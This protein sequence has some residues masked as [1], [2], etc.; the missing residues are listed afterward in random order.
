MRNRVDEILNL[1]NQVAPPRP[2]FEMPGEDV[3]S[4]PVVEYQDRDAVSRVGDST[5]TNE[6]DQGLAF[7][8][9]SLA[10]E[11]PS[12]RDRDLIA[13]AGQRHRARALFYRLKANRY[14]DA[15]HGIDYALELRLVESLAREDHNSPVFFALISI[16]GWDEGLDRENHGCGY[17]FHYIMTKRRGVRTNVLLTFN[18]TED[19]GPPDTLYWEHHGCY[20]SANPDRWGT[21]RC[22]A[23]HSA[24]RSSVY[25]PGKANFRAPSHNARILWSK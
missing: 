21:R 9:R 3:Y 20:P 17:H 12:R 11:F 10:S 24:A 4:H 1:I 23:V 19:V 13:D 8:S 2:M 7:I 5:T 22:R 6:V 18:S 14:V 25:R 16:A 15:T